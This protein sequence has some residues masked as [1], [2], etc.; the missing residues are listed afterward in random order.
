[1]T[2]RK[3]QEK[4]ENLE[5]K[6]AKGAPVRS[7]ARSGWFM[8]QWLANFTHSSLTGTWMSLN[9]GKKHQIYIMKS[10]ELGIILLQIIFRTLQPL[11]SRLQGEIPPL[12]SWV[13]PF[14]TMIGFCVMF[15]KYIHQKILFD[16]HRS[17]R[18]ASLSNDAACFKPGILL[19]NRN[20]I[21]SAA[22]NTIRNHLTPLG[23][24]L[25]IK[26]DSALQQM[27]STRFFLRQD[28]CCINY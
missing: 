8:R 26:T 18:S 14:L 5:D 6:R 3:R 21:S 24:N 9:L 22:P 15:L 25:R 19:I 7:L 4:L 17:S 27:L 2:Q 13:H 1:M 16:I 11:V 12:T 23:C 28:D 10:T 20:F